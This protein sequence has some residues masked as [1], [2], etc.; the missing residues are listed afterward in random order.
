MSIAIFGEGFNFGEKVRMETMRYHPEGDN[1]PYKMIY[2]EDPFANLFEFY[3]HIYKETY[4]SE[5]T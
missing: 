2:F 5:Y 1:K 4:S 3:S